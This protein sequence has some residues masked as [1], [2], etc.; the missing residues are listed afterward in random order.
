[1]S[2]KPHDAGSSPVQ[3]WS[4]DGFQGALSVVTRP[5]YAPDFF[6]CRGRTH[7]GVPSLSA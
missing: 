7:R 4:R 1:M 3:L 5:T 6:P 2:G